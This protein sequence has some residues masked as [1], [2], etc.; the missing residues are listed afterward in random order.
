M[1]SQMRSVVLIMIGAAT[2]GCG[3]REQPVADAIN[4]D[5]TDLPVAGINDEERDAFD[6]GDALFEV[7]LREADGL[8]PVFIRKS[9]ESCHRGDG[10]GPGTV[11]KL[12][13]RPGATLARATIDRLLLGATIR[14]AAV[15]GAAALAG[16]APDPAVIV[17]HRLPPAVFGRGYL[18]AIADDS[19]LANARAVRPGGIAGRVH[20][21]RYGGDAANTDVRFHQHAPGATGLIGRFGVKARIATLDE[22]AADALQSDM[23]LTSPLRARELPNPDGRDDDG[24]PGVDLTIERVNAL[25][26]YTRLVAMPPRVSKHARGPELFARALCSACHVPAL[27]TRADYPIRALAGIDAPVFTDLLLHDMGESL[28]DGVTEGEAGP[29]DFRTAPLIGV[30]FHRALMH[31][32]RARTVEQAIFAH[33]GEGSE[34]NASVDRFEQLRS[35]EQAALVAY[36]QGL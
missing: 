32:G 9:C 30:R 5:R 14:P 15:L 26:D 34:A 3:S 18:E 16:P 27:R 11:A 2:A 21:V 22:F 20:R 24:K 29:R 13:R 7:V 4:A 36:V 35:E 33:R 19:I 10:R 1:R 31:D 8:G 23:G 6:R 17:T 12:G 25:A 28:A